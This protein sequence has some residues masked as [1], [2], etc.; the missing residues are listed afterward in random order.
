MSNP[1]E[2]PDGRYL[3]LVNEEGQHSLWPAFAEVP[4]GWTVAHGEDDRQAC[5]DH[6][7]EHWADM[8]PKSLITTM[9]GT[10]A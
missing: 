10:P 2:N 6:I 3:V 7:N 1:F 9:D 4:A 8:R 5:L